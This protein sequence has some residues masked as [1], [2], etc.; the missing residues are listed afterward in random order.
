[1]N[2]RIY[3]R[4]LTVAISQAKE[5]AVVTRGIRL[6]WSSQYIL[7]KITHIPGNQKE[8]SFAWETGPSK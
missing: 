5:E 2:G 3:T 7:K 1:M 4:L 6:Y 8:I